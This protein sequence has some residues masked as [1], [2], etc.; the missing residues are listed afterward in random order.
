M[1]PDVVYLLTNSI[2]RAALS[3]TL[4]P[5]ALKPWVDEVDAFVSREGKFSKFSVAYFPL[6]PPPFFWD[7]K[8]YKC[9]RFQSGGTC[10]WVSGDI[11]RHAWCSIWVPAPGYQAFT[12]PRELL[13]GNW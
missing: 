6:G 11:G 7:Y 5:G 12:W 10:A 4:T 13:K 3:A 8:C 9:G 2:G 1:L